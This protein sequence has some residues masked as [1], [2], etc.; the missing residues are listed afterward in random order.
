MQGLTD[1]PRADLT[2]E[3]VMAV[4]TGD[5]VA[6]S[7]GCELL[8]LDNQ[9]VEDISDDLA[10]GGQIERDNKADVHGI[11]T[12]NLT[13]ELAWGRD[14]VRLYM[15]LTD[16]VGP[17]RF[18]LG[19]F[20][21]VTPVSTLGESPQSWEIKGYD[22]TQLLLDGPGDV[23][24]VP[25]GSTYVE[26]I[27]AIVAEAGVNATVQLAG[28]RAGATTERVYM[29]VPSD[30]TPVRFLDMANY[31][32]AAIGYKDLWVDADGV[33][34][35]QPLEDLLD[36]GSLTS[37]WTFNTLDAAT[38]ITAPE[39]TATGDTWAAVN[40]WRFFRQTTLADPTPAEGSGIFTYVNTVTGPSSVAQLGRYRR[41]P[42]QVLTAADQV[43]LEAQGRQIIAT[44][45]QVTQTISI[46]VDPLPIAGHQDIVTHIGPDGVARLCQVA[47]WTLPLDGS[48]GAWELEVV[49][50]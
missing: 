31:L 32:L 17:V 49:G 36:P 22:L 16:A 37:T 39:Q 21:L 44:D 45:Q 12:L 27:R 14:R 9:L 23:W 20:S 18:N 19:V 13:R 11:C 24:V 38:D 26:A 43:S 35:S 42:P 29:W 25:F 4:L 1:Q 33:F 34:R 28:D 3:R 15:T 8:D 5:T 50:G 7:T 40:W 30:Q 6:V 41:K 48:R 2:A 46:S 47:S 10:S